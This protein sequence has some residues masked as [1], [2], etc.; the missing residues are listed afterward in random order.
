MAGKFKAFRR[1]IKK[2]EEGS[3]SSGKNRSI[4][5]RLLSG[6]IAMCVVIS[7]LFGAFNGFL[8]YRDAKNNTD[9]RLMESAEAYSQ[10]IENAIDIYKIKIEAI[11]QYTSITDRNKSDGQRKEVMDKLAKDY[12]FLEVTTADVNG[13]ASN[14]ADI[15]Q[16]EYFSQAINGETYISTTMQSEELGKTVLV[17]AAKVNNGE[18]NGVVTGTLD[19]DVF[20]KMIDGVS[21]GKSGYGFITDKAGKVVAHKDRNV[22]SNETNYIELAKS[23]S[24]LKEVAAN[25]QEM[26]TGKS[27]IRTARFKGK[28]LVMGYTPITNTDSWS[29]GVAA[30]QSEMMAGF[31]QSL[32]ITIILAALMILASLHMAFR[33]AGPIVKPL[34]GLAERI[35]ALDEGDLHSEVPQI[36]TGDELEDLSRSFTGTINTLN[37]YINEIS[38]ILSG[39]EKGDCTITA[40]QDYKGD[41][42]QIKDSLN[43]ITYNLNSVFTKIKE[44]SDRVAEGSRQISDASQALASGATEQAATVEELSASVSSV[45]NRAQQNAENVLKATGYVREAV[46]GM[47]EGNTYMEKLDHSMKEIGQASEKISNITKVIEDIA[48]QTNILALNAAVESARAGEAG[49]GFAVVADEVRN[50]AGKSAEAAKQTADLIGHSVQTVSEGVK[51]AYET[52]RI[53]KS[54]AEKS[55]QV[56]HTIQEIAAA[57]NEQVEAIDQ[58][59]QGLTQVSTVVQTNAATAEESSASSEELDAQAQLLKQEVEKFR[60]QGTDPQAEE[61]RVRYEAAAAF[62]VPVIEPDHTYITPSA[63]IHD[64]AKY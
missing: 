55:G 57:S 9:M 35:K 21:I 27:D 20:S 26:I 44:S 50:L 39:L 31:Y 18:Y 11:A 61:E 63:N 56:E 42:V 25:I 43:G 45:S 52:T 38:T 37:S 15:S 3:D 58:I 46:T 49:K 16:L 34:I 19:A 64:S 17:I 60:L 54:A 30:N 47:D 2:S 51:I 7:I 62:E 59:N 41:F 53:L 1:V 13:K 14:G 10:A 22:V 4:K 29:I 33:I 40:T 6:I 8:F 12:G 48:F 24:S 28:T 36:N 32:I 23:D 5:G